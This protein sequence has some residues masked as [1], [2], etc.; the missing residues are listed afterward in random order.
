[1]IIYVP[2]LQ[3]VF[4][5]VPLSALELGVCFGLSFL[6]FISVEIEKWLIR[7]GRIYATPTTPLR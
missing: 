1:V 5:T 3:P 7:H 6:V 4:R 2:A